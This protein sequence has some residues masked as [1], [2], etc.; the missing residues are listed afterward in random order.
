VDR[1]RLLIWLLRAAGTIEILAFV[2][3]IMPR[4]WMEGAHAWLGLGQMPVGPLLMFMIRQASYSYGMHGISLWL[5][6]MDVE[7]FRLLILFNGIAYL[8]A[9]P[10]F[11][12]IDYTSGVP[13]WWTLGDTASCLFFGGG[14]LWLMRRASGDVGERL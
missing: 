5:L 11:F 14:V 6:A 9:A 3:V 13:T 7:R 8:L 2:A 1:K 10:V 4:A 12:L